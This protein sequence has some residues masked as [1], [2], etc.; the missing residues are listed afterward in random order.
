MKNTS[1]ALANHI[2]HQVTTLCTCL[3]IRRRDGKPFFFT[4]HDMP[5][6]YANNEYVPYNSFARF[7]ITS[8]VDL[9]VDQLEIRGM[10]SSSSIA[11]TD[12]ESG[13]FD[14]STINV[15]ALNWADP[16]MGRIMLRTGHLGE[17]IMGEDGTFRAELRGLSQVYATKI[18]ESYQAECRADLGDRRCKVPL[19]PD[20]WTANTAYCI[21]DYV[22]SAIAAG[23][24][25]VNLGLVNPSFEDDGAVNNVSSLTGWTSYGD[26]SVGRWGTF[27][28][29]STFGGVPVT[30][31]G[32]YYVGHIN[33]ID[34][35][36]TH[37][38][39][40][41]GMYQDIDLVAEGISTTDLDTG[42]C[43]VTA[44][45]WYAKANL[46]S[47]TARLKISAIS[48][49]GALTTIY[50]SGA[51]G[52]AEDFWIQCRI[53]DL[54]IPTLTRSLRFDLFSHKVAGN[55][56]GCAF[57]Y[58]TA[59]VNSP[60]GT[61]GSSDENGGV[62]FKALNSGTSGASAPA[63][64]NV[65]DETVVDNDINWL[66]V[67]SFVE[68]A[69]VAAIDLA[70]PKL[71]VP[72]TLANNSAGYYD[73]GILIWETG[74]N[75]GAVHEIFS[76][77]GANLLLFLRP[78]FVM[79][80]GDRFRI[81]PGCDKTRATCASKFHNAVNFRGEPDVPGMDEY[82]KTPNVGGGTQFFINAGGVPDDN[83]GIL[84]VT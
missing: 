79:A 56:A 18:G 19:E 10:L 75:S 20:E 51:L 12:I 23:A 82:I 84:P 4:D 16:S 65:I 64:T 17:F 44:S 47:T 55:Y 2:Q 27:H 33:F 54:L 77:D 1:D 34:G 35:S 7:S 48:T 73:G 28:T 3:L 46:T 43:R 78:V 50:D 53:R 70:I 81:H 5:V 72:T 24:G 80:I 25:A 83:G 6:T 60:S 45:M 57:D 52:G 61:T 38:S 39:V 30:T 31:H 63:F 26:T 42:L 11:R 37:Q 74:A 40:D 32:T 41:L 62:A 15:F 8:S 21:G 68:T 71:F 69:T 36:T 29:P 58:I 67:N 49:T 22:V 13:L 66:I 59:Y 14:W 9:D 76:W